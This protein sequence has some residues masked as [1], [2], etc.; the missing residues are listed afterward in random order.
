MNPNFWADYMPLAYSPYENEAHLESVQQWLKR[1][2]ENSIQRTISVNCILLY[3][4]AMATFLRERDIFTSVYLEEVNQ[5][6][7]VST[8]I[9]DTII[10]LAFDC[11][12]HYYVS[13]I[14][15]TFIG[16]RNFRT[17]FRVLGNK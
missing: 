9:Y 10:I 12:W 2:R 11:E 14:G 3:A 4:T 17:I 16:R 13:I 15:C 5:H 8:I 6:I 1:D 7:N